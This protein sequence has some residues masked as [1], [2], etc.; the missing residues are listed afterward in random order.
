[1]ALCVNVYLDSLPCYS[2]LSLQH[3]TYLLSF[4]AVDHMTNQNLGWGFEN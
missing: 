1:M 3:V 4:F 2:Q